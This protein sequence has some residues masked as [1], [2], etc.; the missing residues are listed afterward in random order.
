LL[1]IASIGFVVDVILFQ[2][3]THL[4]DR[5]LPARALGFDRITLIRRYSDSGEDTDD[6]DGDNQLDECQPL[7]FVCVPFHS[8]ASL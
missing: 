3:A 7:L 6:R 5:G 8:F 2:Q 1:E 4:L